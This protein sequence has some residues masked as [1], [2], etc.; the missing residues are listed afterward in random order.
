MLLVCRGTDTPNDL[1]FWS[2]WRADHSAMPDIFYGPGGWQVL[3]PL[4]AKFHTSGV[5]CL[6]DMVVWMKDGRI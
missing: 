1:T 5:D 2:N 4:Y 6:R 3:G